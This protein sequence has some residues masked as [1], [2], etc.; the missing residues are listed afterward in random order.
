RVDSRGLAFLTHEDHQDLGGSARLVERLVPMIDVFHESLSALVLSRLSS[1]GLDDERA[2]HHVDEDGD[3][4]L[5]PGRLAA[6]L[7]LADDRD[8]LGLPGLRGLD[9]ADARRV[10]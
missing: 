7:Q 10:L 2:F 9:L 3:R 8:D 1:F 5:M 4:M 6:W